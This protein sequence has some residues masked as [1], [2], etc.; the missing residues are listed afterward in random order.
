[1]DVN[2]DGA[3]NDPAF[4]ESGLSSALSAAGCTGGTNSFAERN[5]C[6]EDAAHSLDLRASIGLPVRAPDGSRLTL[7]FDAFNLVSSDVGVVDRALVLI[8]PSGT[9]GVDGQGNVTLPLVANPNFG[10]LISRRN[11]PRLFRIGLRMEY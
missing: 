1:V 9:L 11:D 6:R 5:S 2:G 8:D 3:S 4:L 7:V 10:N